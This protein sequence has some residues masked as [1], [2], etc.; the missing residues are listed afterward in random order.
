MLIPT[1]KQ[2]C[3]L[4]ETKTYSAELHCQDSEFSSACY[5]FCEYAQRIHGL[6]FISGTGA[7]VLKKNSSL[8]NGCYRL[9]LN[10]TITLEAGEVQGIHYGFATLLQLMTPQGKKFSCPQGFIEDK[11]D[12]PYRGLMVDVARQWHSCA[13]LL[14]YVDLCYFYKLSKL[15]LHF[16]DDQSFTLPIT[17]FPKLP[18][19]GRS[20]TREE[21]D[22]IVNYAWERGIELIPEIDVPGHCKAIQQGD[23][24]TFGNTGV[25]PASETVLEA[26][27]CIFHEVAELFPHSPCIHI[28]GD[29]VDVTKWANCSQSQNYMRLHGI[30]S[31]QELYAVYIREISQKILD[32]GRTP[33]VWEGFHKEYNHL[34][35]K[36]VLIM[37][38]EAAAQP[39][40]DLA[41]DGYTLINCSCKPL[42]IISPDLYWSAE[43]ILQW[44]PYRWNHWMDHSIAYPNPITIKEDSCTVLGGELCS[45]GDF[46]HN[47]ENPAADCIAEFNLLRDT[48][49]ALAETAWNA[50][51]EISSLKLSDFQ[52]VDHIWNAIWQR[53]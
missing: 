51:P 21:I 22:L 34:I 19:P 50:G 23:P 39:P 20:Y 41:S 12:I 49:P 38:W 24:D 3:L 25:L 36:D 44:K 4:E 5:R 45:W 48:L 27:D 15:H 9:T 18:T 26:L 17:S 46:M 31:P 11:P 7:I 1:P 6:S 13:F 30:S 10:Q 29:E 37:A 52:Q 33:I 8:K 32:M 2:S 35:S 47:K 28:G 14:K 53:E 40:Y 16:S 43:E 42:Y